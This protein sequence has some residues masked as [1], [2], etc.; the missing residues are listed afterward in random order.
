MTGLYKEEIPEFYKMY[1][2]GKH[3]LKEIAEWF[4]ISYCIAHKY[5]IRRK[6][7]ESN[8]SINNQN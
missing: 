1:D 7:Y 3:Y 5:V 4:G 6:D 2:S 8:P